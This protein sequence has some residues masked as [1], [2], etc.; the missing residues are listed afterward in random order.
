MIELIFVI[1]ILGI[2][3]AT[4]LPKLAATRD[5]A[6]LTADIQKMSNCIMEAGTLYTARGED[7]AAGDG[8]VCDEVKCYTINF[9]NDGIDFIVSLNP[10]GADYCARVAEAGD[11][12]AKTYRFK[13]TRVSY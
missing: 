1:V 6:K 13:G 4:A 7:I 3:A 2:L 5:D 12:L 11:H 9:A 10:G 8:T